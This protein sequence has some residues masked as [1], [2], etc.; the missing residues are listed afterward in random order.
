MCPS[1][2]MNQDWSNPGMDI[3]F[4]FTR[5]FFLN[6]QILPY[7]WDW[8]HN[9]FSELRRSELGDLGLES[10]YFLIKESFWLL[11]LLSFLGHQM[12]MWCLLLW[13]PPS[14]GDKHHGGRPVLWGWE[15]RRMVRAGVSDDVTKPWNDPWNHPEPI[16]FCEVNNNCLHGSSYWWS[17]F[18]TRGKIFLIQNPTNH[19]PFNFIVGLAILWKH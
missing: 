19:F 14:W 16:D 4:S 5:D 6:P 3:P 17:D 18:V 15:K 10:F 9:L 12:R 1:S 11:P 13:Q 7:V 2:E 8:A